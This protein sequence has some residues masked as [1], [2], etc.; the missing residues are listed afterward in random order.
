MRKD[1]KA[2]Y[3]NLLG[4]TLL[5]ILTRLQKENIPFVRKVSEFIYTR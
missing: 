5:K 4:L 1:Y 2:T 3:L